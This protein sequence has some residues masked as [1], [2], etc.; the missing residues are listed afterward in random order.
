MNKTQPLFLVCFLLLVG[1]FA[2]NWY[3]NDVTI[4]QENGT[5]KGEVSL[6]RIVWSG[7]P[8]GQGTYTYAGGSK[9]VG[10]FKGGKK[11]G[12]GTFTFGSGPHSGDKYVGEFK[13]DKWNG[14]GTFTFGTGPH[15]GDTYVGEFKDGNWH[16]QGA[17]TWSDGSTYVGEFKDRKF[18]GQGTWTHPDGRKY[19]GE[20]KDDKTWNGTEYD[21]DGNVTATYSEGVRTEK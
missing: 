14:Q 21:K 6:G 20:F 7:V 17:Y 18:Q 8:H 10:E 5:Y 3:V 2:F 13:D 1:L 4:E 11:K 9:Y 19:V 16:G 12:Q 15:L